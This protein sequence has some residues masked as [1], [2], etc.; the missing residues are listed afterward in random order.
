MFYA[1]LLST[2]ADVIP[3]EPAPEPVPD[4][5]ALVSE[6]VT[7]ACGDVYSTQEVAFTFVVVKDGEELARRRHVW[8]P[9]TGE[10]TSS[11]EGFEATLTSVYP[12]VA[13]EGVSAEDADQAHGAFIND[14]YWLLAPC[15]V[16]DPGV[17]RSS[18][19]DSHLTLT[20]DGVG[21][22]PGDTYTLTF[23]GHTFDIMRWDFVLQ[24]GREGAY[25]WE[26]YQ[27]FGPLRLATLH[28]SIVDGA[29]SEA[30]VIRFEDVAV[31]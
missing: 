30:F 7:A 22:T 5:T 31:K 1:L 14:S 27:Q 13:A 4:V 18:D 19:Q 8:H 23:N 10:V 2:A 25:T 29:P 3:L 15:K 20:F 16:L 24:S 9:Q 21:R 17:R 28:R 6:M 26:G 11:W 12:M